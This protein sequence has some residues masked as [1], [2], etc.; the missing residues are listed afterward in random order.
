MR[1][2]GSA[3]PGWLAP[4]LIIG[5]AA[6][7]IVALDL[8]RRDRQGPRPDDVH[9]FAGL[10]YYNR[11]DSRIV[12]PKRYGLGFGR[13][14]NFAHPVAWLVVLV[15]LAFAALSAANHHS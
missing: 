2:Y 1:R 10:I 3:V 14:L 5:V 13:T 9:W 11:D 4:A 7:L 8:G 6:L 12:V 15:P